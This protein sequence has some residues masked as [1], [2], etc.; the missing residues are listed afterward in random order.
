MPHWDTGYGTWRALGKP[1]RGP[2][3]VIG[4]M[5]C[6]LPAHPQFLYGSAV[7]TSALD[8]QK[9]GYT[10]SQQQLRGVPMHFDIKLIAVIINALT[11]F[12][13]A[14]DTHRFGAVMLVVVMIATGALMVVQHLPTILA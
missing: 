3:A 1:T 2:T 8:G 14:L 9:I 11:W 5:M 4:K 10:E 12:V 6:S 13:R 7:V